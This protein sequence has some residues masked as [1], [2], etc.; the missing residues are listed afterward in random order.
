MTDLFKKARWSPYLVGTLL[1]VL[2]WITFY[3]MEK[4]L[5]TSTTMVKVAGLAEGVVSESHVRNNDYMAKH[6]VGTPAI[7]WQFA[8]VL[9]M[10]F[11]AFIAARLARSRFSE[12]VPEVWAARF[13]PS[14]AKRYIGAFLGGAILLFGARLAGGCTSGHGIS[15]SLQLALSSW[16]FLLSMFAAGTAAAFLIYGKEGR[17]HV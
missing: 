6:L 15:G 14:K 16:T 3:F 8:L 7:D 4:A 11:G 13:G 12:T 1:G 2:S 17:A 9:T 5:G 10:G